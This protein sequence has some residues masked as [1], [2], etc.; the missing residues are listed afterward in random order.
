M[1]ICKRTLESGQK[2][3]ENDGVRPV[4]IF[5]DSISYEL[6]RPI[7]QGG[8]GCVYEALQ[9][10]SDAFRKRVAIKIIRQEYSSLPQFRKNF[11]GEAT[12]VADLIHANIVQTYHLGHA[13]KQ[14]Y[15][16]MEYVHGV[17]LEQFMLQHR[18]L[19]KAI[20]CDLAAFVISR[21][22]RALAYAHIHR[23]PSGKPLGIV[24]RDVSP[25]NIMLSYGGDV[26]LTD[27]GIA[28]A[29][30]LMYS[31]E[32]EIIAG[33]SDYLSPEQARL[34]VTDPR[35]DLFS[36]GVVLAEMILGY[37]PFLG[38]TPETSR[39]NICSMELPRWFDER[40]DIGKPL[41]KILAKSLERPREKR[42][43]KAVELMIDLERLLYSRGYG[44]TNEKLASYLR[45]LYKDGQA[46][47]DDLSERPVSIALNPDEANE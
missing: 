14:Y 28:K 19:G 3:E 45:S 27:F 8:M 10:G 24:H 23:D 36:C 5:S 4:K 31:E 42:Y 6:L 32:G 20:P 47:E 18:A 22:S 43:Q 40:P 16:V 29:F 9:E 33:R 2:L 11:I 35:A 38:E 25:K 44:P 17:N 13:H 37:N 1:H 41:T 15:M 46:Y 12:L 30:N 34:E 7:A 21:I 26:K 39:E